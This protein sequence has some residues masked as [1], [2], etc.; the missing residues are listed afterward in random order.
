M[1]GQRDALASDLHPQRRPPSPCGR[2]AARPSSGKRK[3]PDR[4]EDEEDDDGG[5]PSTITAPTRKPSPGGPEQDAD[6]V[7]ARVR[8]GL[9][10]QGHDH[11]LDAA[12]PFGSSASPGSPRRAGVHHRRVRSPHLVGVVSQPRGHRRLVAQPAERPAVVRRTAG[13]PQE[14]QTSVMAENLRCRVTAASLTPRRIPL[15]TRWR[16]DRGWLPARER[17]PG[18]VV[19]N[20]FVGPC[21]GL[22]AMTEG[23]GQGGEDCAA[24]ATRSALSTPRTAAS[25]RSGPYPGSRWK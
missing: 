21:R 5:E 20:C 11:R 13:P 16:G 25:F 1:R 12:S 3:D 14:A 22:L 17:G 24:T 15:S 7:Y 18:G 23:G 10:L 6:A 4:R 19:Q 2:P 8:D 9:L